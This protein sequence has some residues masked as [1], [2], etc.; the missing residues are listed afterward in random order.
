MPPDF[1]REQDMMNL[2]SQVAGFFIRLTGFSFLVDAT[3]NLTYLPESLAA[4]GSAKGP[5]V[6]LHE[7]DAVMIVVRVML[8]ALVGLAFLVFSRTV[9]KSVYSWAECSDTGNSCRERYLASL[10]R[11]IKS[12]Y[13]KRSPEAAK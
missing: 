10:L 7:F 3:I 1:Y 2:L 13:R 4:A 6:D 9:I 5:F 8:L 12:H 11:K